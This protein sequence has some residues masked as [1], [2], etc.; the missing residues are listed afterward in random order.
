MTVY[1]CYIPALQEISSKLQIITLISLL[2]LIFLTRLFTPSNALI[3]I[4]PVLL[5]QLNPIKTLQGYVRQ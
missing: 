2:L 3:A 4:K 5:Q 1:I